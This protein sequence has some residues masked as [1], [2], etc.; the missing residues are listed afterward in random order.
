MSALIGIGG[1]LMSVPILSAYVPLRTAI[2]T[3]A[4]IGVPISLS[5]V[6]GY[7]LMARPESCASCIGFVFIPA[8]FAAGLAAVV[9]AP[10]GARAAHTLPIGIL[11]R[12]FAVLLVLI[13]IDLMYKTLA[14]QEIA[15]AFSTAFGVF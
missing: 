4:A 9:S 10:Y 1:G 14:P 6:A 7:L 15:Q 11:R 5:A 3:A 12:M 13:A 8:V 2:G